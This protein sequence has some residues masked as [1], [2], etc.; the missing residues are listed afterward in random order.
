MIIIGIDPG[1]TGAMAMLGGF[2]GTSIGVWDLPVSRENKRTWIDGGALLKMIRPDWKPLAA[3]AYI[4][5][6]HAMPQQGISSAFQFGTSFGSILGAL[7]VMGIP[8]V[9]ATPHQWKKDLNLAREKS[10]ALDRAR[11]LFPGVVLNLK[12]HE[13]RA[14]ALLIAHWAYLKYHRKESH[15]ST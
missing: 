3:V 15:E 13:G 4:E 1:L 10:S 9:F 11:L 14:E 2:N 5:S 7:Q 8:I 12:K 6:V